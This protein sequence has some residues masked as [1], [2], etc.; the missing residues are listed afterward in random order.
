MNTALQLILV[1]YQYPKP[2]FMTCSA[3][4]TNPPLDGY[5]CDGHQHFT[6]NKAN[7]NICKQAC[8]ASPKCGAMSFNPVDGTC[9]LAMQPC[10]LARKQNEYR[11]MVFRQEEQVQCAMW[12]RDQAGIVPAGMVA[13]EN[14]S[15]VARVAVDGDVLVGVTSHPGQH[16]NTYIAHEG[17]QIY[18]PTQD[19]LTVHPNCTMAWV[20]YTA[21]ATLPRNVI[22][23]GMLANGRRLYSILS[24]YAPGHVWVIGVYA[25][26]DTEAYYPFG[27]SNAVTK[28]DILVVV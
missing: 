12:V 25:E 21:G 18:Y 11:L 5:F 19:L 27:G 22:V 1:L 16:W 14:K 26:G 3:R 10:T 8:F 2:S 13:T 9:L 24:W 23:T 7:E 28:C 20:P 17:H 15:V 6:S 4:Y